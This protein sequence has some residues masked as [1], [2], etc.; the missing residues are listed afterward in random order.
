MASKLKMI[1][2]LN[3]GGLALMRFG[4]YR[5]AS[6]FLQKALEH[7]EA[8]FPYDFLGDEEMLLDELPI[9]VSPALIGPHTSY[10]QEE[11]VIGL[12]DRG[13]YF[14]GKDL[15][16]RMGSASVRLYTA[17]GINYN[18]ALCLHIEAVSKPKNQTFLLEKAKAIYQMACGLLN[19]SM[20]QR[21][22]LV[23]HFALVNNLA[24]VSAQLYEIQDTKRWLEDLRFV[25]WSDSDALN[26]EE[27]IIFRTNLMTNLWYTS[28]PSAAA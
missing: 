1:I 27:R 13:F 8:S 21:E 25:Y 11:S 26:Q 12:F 4:D 2:D 14:S 3:S 6:A 19:S 7:L 17:I 15:P 18:L 24:S 28:R 20:E 10:C 23:L 5:R 9:E 16:L 22:A